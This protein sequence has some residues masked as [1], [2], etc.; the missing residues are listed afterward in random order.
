MRLSFTTLALLAPFFAASVRADESA[1]QR[2][3]NWHQWRGPLANGTAPHGKPPVKWDAKTNIKW[4][5]ELPGLGTSTPI[6]W[7]DLV[8]VLT[9]LDTGRT[10][11]AADIPQPQPRFPKKTGA[12]QTYHQF[13]VLALDRKTGAV[14]WKRV[15]AEKVPHEGH[16]NTHSYAAYSPT[17]DGKFLYVSFGSFGLYCY[18]FAGKLQWKRTDLPRLETRLGWGEGGAPVVHGDSLI[19]ARDQEGPSA[20][21][22]LNARTGET[23]WKVERDEVTTWNTPLVVD[24]KGRTQIIV[25][26]TKFIRSY[27]L[28]D[29]RVLWKCGGLTVNCIPSAVRYEDSVICMSGYK[30]AAAF[31][32]PLD[33]SGDVTSSDK[34]LWTHKRGTPYVPSPLLTGDRLYFTQSNDALLTC[35]NVKT[36][37]VILER[38]RLG[39]LR[40]LYASPVE[41][42]GRIYLTDREGTTMVLQRG[43]EVKTLSVNRLDESI[44]ASPA[45]VGKQLFLRGAKH[46]YCI[47]DE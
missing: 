8:F 20:L 46:L 7:D 3:D 1:K 33:A 22:V 17:T 28:A 47:E 37:T 26:A 15:A 6:V 36:G 41:A 44:D 13:I 24:Y 9:A 4:K 34:I 31:R 45:I 42:D 30:G 38:E 29:G 16:H 32:I 10:A 21:Y 43:D 14:R 27:D 2:L 18:D 35:L 39:G 11:A 23:R 5:T 25:T 19:V 12:P 40:T